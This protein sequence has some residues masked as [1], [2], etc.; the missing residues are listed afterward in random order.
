MS[1]IKQAEFDCCRLEFCLFLRVKAVQP[2][3]E[4]IHLIQIDCHLLQPLEDRPVSTDF[5]HPAVS[6]QR[7]SQAHASEQ[8]HNIGIII[9]LDRKENSSLSV[10]GVL[11]IADDCLDHTLF[12]LNV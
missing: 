4:V 1:H 8:L 9:L 5:I 6:L 12:L 7:V 10:L 2:L 3:G 11:R